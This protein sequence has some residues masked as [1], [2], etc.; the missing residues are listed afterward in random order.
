MIQPDPRVPRHVA[1]V[2]DGNRRWAA[3]R[4]LSP[5][6]GWK[7]GEQRLYDLVRWAAQGGVSVI[8]AFAFSSENWHRSRSEVQR[9]LLQ[10]SSAIKNRRDE[11]TERRIGVKFIGRRDRL[12]VIQ[13]R[14]IEELER[15]TAYV[16]AATLHLIVA[17]DYG[18]L[19]DI[20]RAGRNLARMVQQGQLDPDDIDEAVFSDQTSLGAWPPID[21]L[22]RSGGEQRLSNFAL[23]PLAYTE[24]Y[25]TSSLWPDFKVREWQAALNS[26]AHRERRFGAD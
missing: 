3:L 21:L 16:H 23:W 4:D 5:D 25:F 15:A 11:L 9:L 19:W 17:F 18:G 20:A 22:I 2:M 14:A 12:G 24:L 8:T 13:R 7:Q 10:L 26:Y 1:V 6:E